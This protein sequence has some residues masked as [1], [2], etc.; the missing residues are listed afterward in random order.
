MQRRVGGWGF[1]IIKALSKEGRIL[2]IFLKCTERET[3]RLQ[4]NET[5]SGG[6]ATAVV[7]TREI[8]RMLRERERERDG[9][10]EMDRD[11]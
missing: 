3:C 7:A 5:E 1:F 10:R 2:K 8:K 11:G 9:E 6:R 4:W